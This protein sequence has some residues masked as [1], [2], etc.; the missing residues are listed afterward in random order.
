MNFKIIET[1]VRCPRGTFLVTYLG[2]PMRQGGLKKED[3][4]GLIEQNTKMAGKL[5][6]T[7]L[8]DR[9]ETNTSNCGPISNH[10]IHSFSI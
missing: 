6:K 8:I 9:R 7:A 2:I 4:R 1:I 10:S 3:W 5:A